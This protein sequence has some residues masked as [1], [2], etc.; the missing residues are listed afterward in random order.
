MC[1]VKSAEAEEDC[2]YVLHAGRAAGVGSQ[3]S[4][5]GGVLK[6]FFL[7]VAKSSMFWRVV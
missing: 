7:L 4:A 1:A 3:A 2:E 6:G 5:D